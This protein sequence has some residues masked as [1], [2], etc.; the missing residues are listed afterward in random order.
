MNI[1]NLTSLQRF[2]EKIPLLVRGKAGGDR[3]RVLEFTI[4]TQDRFLSLKLKDYEEDHFG[5]LSRIHWIDLCRGSL[6][7]DA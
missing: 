4:V 7:C 5:T 3:G 2:V 6:R 1:G